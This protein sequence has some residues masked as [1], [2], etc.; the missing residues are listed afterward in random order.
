M[1][2]LRV[3]DTMRTLLPTLPLLQTSIEIDYQVLKAASQSSKIPVSTLISGS[4]F[5]YPDVIP[6]PAST[7]E[8]EFIKAIRLKRQIRE[9]AKMTENVA[10]N[11]EKT[12]NGE[13]MQS[14]A[15]S[16]TM[17]SLVFLAFLA[18]YFAGEL[19]GVSQYLVFVT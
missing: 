6:N 1:V 14:A 10:G 7:P 17:V 4:S 5:I 13:M 2:L 9:Y 19:L 15:F 12:E 11:T 8:P 16:V 3:T 18:G